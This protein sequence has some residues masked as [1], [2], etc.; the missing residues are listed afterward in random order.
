M[1][2]GPVSGSEDHLLDAATA[3][4]VASRVAAFDRFFRAHPGDG[5]DGV[6]LGRAVVE[7]L[8]WEVA[9]GRV[10]DEG[11]SGWWS[12]VNGLLVLDVDGAGSGVKV[13]TDGCRAWQ[14]YVAASPERQQ[15]A[16][17]RAHEL[18]MTAAVARCAPL[19][20]REPASERRFTAIVLAVLDGATRRCT[21]TDSPRLGA[22]VRSGYPSTYPIGEDRLAA[23]VASMEERQ[24]RQ[25]R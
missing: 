16:L 14:A 13:D 25:R 23:L 10:S 7:F 19:L 20:D 5:R 18:S 2:P 8:A 22:S 21:P 24:R 4:S 12:A 11:G 17:W 6:G 3:L 15:A 9:S 1:S